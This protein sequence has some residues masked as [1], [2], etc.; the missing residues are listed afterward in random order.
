MIM[1]LNRYSAEIG[2]IQTKLINLVTGDYYETTGN[3]KDGSF[4]NEALL[5]LELYNELIN[6]ITNDEEGLKE[7]MKNF[8][9]GP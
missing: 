3:K 2:I 7:K 5:T 6:K 9:I 1:D 8:K 4:R